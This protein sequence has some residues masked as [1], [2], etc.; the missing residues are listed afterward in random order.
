MKIT[1]YSDKNDLITKLNSIAVALMIA[2][3]CITAVLARI[4]L[5]ANLQN[6]VIVLG[7]V[8]IFIFASLLMTKRLFIPIPALITTSFTFIA[9]MFTLLI[10]SE[11]CDLSA[12]QYIFY[13]VIP[14]FVIG[15]KIDG[16]CIMR[17]V[18]YISLITLPMA[19]SF[20]NIQYEQ[21]T[22]AY[23]GNV[24]SLLTSVTVAMI[25]FK[26]YCKQS[27]I[28]VKFSY[29]YNLYLLIQMLLY[30]NRGAVL[31]IIFCLIVLM[32]NSYGENTLKPLSPP[33]ILIIITVGIVGIVT[34][35]NALPLLEALSSFLSSTFH[36]VP[37]FITKM[38]K[39]MS[40]GDTS[41]GRDTI[42][43]FT[44]NAIFENPIIGNGIKTFE[45][46][47]KSKTT[48]KWPYPHNYILQYLF[49]YGII[50]GLVPVYLS[51]SLAVKT[52]FSRIK[53]KKEFALC[54]TLV[55]LNIPKLFVSTDP[56]ASTTIWMLIT[57]SLIYIVNNNQYFSAYKNRLHKKATEDK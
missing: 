44:T 41:N 54:C 27:N 25:H 36:S 53:E 13:A 56:W 26:L 51:L 7:A 2:A 39:Y 17:Y 32:I 47:V 23:M 35:I 46:Y 5:F 55:C 43:T 38:I 10:N 30:G 45:A 29:L 16:E 20:F 3:P 9:Y 31:C 8:C 11:Q 14:I 57:Y 15:Q 34:V 18:L 6:N 21:Y 42:S 4:K 19:N 12:V 50:F 40:S 22:Q 28:L 37:S 52:V 48:F 1:L 49:E 33:K 24:Y